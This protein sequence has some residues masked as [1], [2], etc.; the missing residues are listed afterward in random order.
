MPFHTSTCNI[1]KIF[2]PKIQLRTNT[3]LQYFFRLFYFAKRNSHCCSILIRPVSCF[4]WGRFYT[5]HVISNPD[6][7]GVLFYM[8]QIWY[9]SRYLQSWS[10]RCPVLYEADFIHFTLSPIL[11]RTVSCFRW[12]RFYTFHAI[13]KTDQNGVRFY[14][15][16]ILYISRYLQSWSDQCPVLYEADFIHFTLSPRHIH[17]FYFI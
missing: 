9:I 10:D 4:T 11:I 2:L 7:N 13:S 16:Q 15:R 1:Y 3:S 17:N 12:G 5:F 8:R 6:Q 14:M